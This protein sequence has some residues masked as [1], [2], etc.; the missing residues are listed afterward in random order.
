MDAMEEFGQWLKRRRRSLGLTQVELGR[1][2]G[3]ASETL[4]K[5]EAGEQR[6]SRQMA[7][8]LAMHLDIAP[9]ERE[10]FVRFARSDTHVDHALSRVPP[11]PLVSPAPLSSLPAPAGVPAVQPTAPA[12]AVPEVQLR[13]PSLIPTELSSFVGRD[14]EL[15]AITQLLLRPDVRLLTVIGPP[16]IGKTRLALQAAQALRQQ[17]SDDVVFVSLASLRNPD[18]VVPT[19]AQALAIREIAG[20]P[21]LE[22][23][24][25]ALRDRSTLL[26]LDNFEQVVPAATQIAALLVAIPLTKALVT[27]QVVLSIRGEQVYV[28]PPMPRPDLKQFV[29]AADLPAMLQEYEAARLFVA[30]AQA[31]QPAFGLTAANARCVAEICHLLDG[32]PLAIELAAARIV[33]FP[34]CAML[35]ALR[36]N[37][38]KPLKGAA[39]DAPERHHTL[40]AAIDWSYSLLSAAEQCLFRQLSV[41]E[42]GFTLE[43]AAAVCAVDGQPGTDVADALE[44]LVNKSLAWAAEAEDGQLRY[45][46]LGIV[47]A[48]GGELLAQSGREGELRQ[49]HAEFLAGLV[50]ESRLH[51]RGADQ[52]IWLK[53]LEAEH[54]NLRAAIHWSCS[55]AGV[56]DLALNLVGNLGLFWEMHGHLTEGRAWIAQALAA[57]RAAQPTETRIKALSEAGSLATFQGDYV[58]ASRSYEE[59]LAASRQSGNKLHEMYLLINLGSVATERGAYSVARAYLEE[60]LASQRDMNNLGGMAAAL[61]YLGELAR[62]EEDFAAAE[63]AYLES[64]AL[65]RQQE[66]ISAVAWTLHNLACVCRQR[67]DSEQAADLFR[68]SLG[69][70]RPLGYLRGLTACLIGFAGIAADRNNAELAVRLFGAATFHKERAGISTSPAD[71]RQ[72]HEGLAHVRAPLSPAAFQAAWRAGETMTLEQAL[73]LTSRV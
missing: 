70:F 6:P 73:D 64:L 2:T 56:V 14:R 50:T 49:R 62:C 20:Q 7:E 59:G 52:A 68:Q 16:G 11:V 19:I 58:A 63:K 57:D 13:R 48:Y 15:A 12:P 30:R 34:P 27:S 60:S 1:L 35:G 54:D 4:R 29:L 3:Y 23:L 17:Y 22:T 31:R 69:L 9:D 26:L 72:Y 46:R 67:E 42:G 61:L 66:D 36:E 55:S 45:W 32:L 65:Y 39:Q 38:L 37:L 25:D 8:Q 41:F 5:V 44:S 51:L 40:R 28:T 43:A 47:H 53:R 24:Q 18:L 71:R 21:L 10:R 33:M